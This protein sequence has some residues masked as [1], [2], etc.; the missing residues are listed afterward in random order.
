MADCRTIIERAVENRDAPFVVAMTASSRGVTW[1]GAAGDAAEGRR[2]AEDT[3]F[4]ILSMSKAVGA[5]MVMILIDRGRLSADTPLDDVLPEFGQ[6][7]VLDGFDGDR[8]R[9][10]APKSK[11]TVRHLL[12]HTSGFVYEFWNA[13]QQRYMQLTG[14]PTVLGGLD[15]ALF[16][17]LAFDPG[18][19]WDYGIGPDWI[20][21]LVEAVDGRRVDRF[22]IE[23]IFAPLGMGDTRFE[24]DDDLRARLATV[25]ARTSDGGFRV[26]DLTP[27]SRPEVYGMG[28]CLYSTAPD[29]MRFLR[30]LLGQGTLEGTRMLSTHAV[31]AMLANQTGALE[32]GPMASVAPRVSADV[33]LFPGTR[34]THSLTALRVEDDV[35]G[36]RSAGSQGWAGA[37]NS[38]FWLDPKMDV[39][40]LFMTQLKPF[41]DPHLMDACEAFERSVYAQR[42]RT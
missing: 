8:P 11:C 10:R 38:H 23:E 5:A 35:P 36:M 21:K 34:K 22:G 26:S 1:S 37:L 31:E 28:Y 25:Y 13:N 3:V 18:S 12:T 9:L 27:P 33:D 24:V 40:G 2:A 15:R 6:V 42:S 29:Y 32:I 20:G 39:A 19:R 41:A 16:Y 17:P 7:Q 14:H 4:R 30:M